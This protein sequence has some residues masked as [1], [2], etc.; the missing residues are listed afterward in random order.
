MSL[1]SIIIF[2]VEKHFC[3]RFQKKNTHVTTLAQKFVFLHILFSHIPYVVHTY[4]HSY[5]YEL[6]IFPCFQDVFIFVI[7]M[8]IYYFIISIGP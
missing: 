6:N 7:L 3:V 1:I 5:I 2:V 8:I 4:F